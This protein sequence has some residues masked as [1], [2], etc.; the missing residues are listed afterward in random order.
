MT[1]NTNNSRQGIDNRSQ[2]RA[3]EDGET[4]VNKQPTK[5]ADGNIPK[6]TDD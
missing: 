1:L 6:E 2:E 4:E 3:Q 5:G